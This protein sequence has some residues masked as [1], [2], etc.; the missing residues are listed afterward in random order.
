MLIIISIH[1]LT[2][3]H[4]DHGIRYANNAELYED[5]SLSVG[6]HTFYYNDQFNDGWSGGYWEV[7][8][9]CGGWPA[10]PCYLPVV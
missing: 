3:R 9:H 7:Q 5:V 1:R 8:D 6:N 4:G 2:T 10:L